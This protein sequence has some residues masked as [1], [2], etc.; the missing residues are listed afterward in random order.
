VASHKG[1]AFYQIWAMAV[2]TVSLRSFGILAIESRVLDLGSLSLLSRVRVMMREWI[3]VH[4]LRIADD[5]DTLSEQQQQEYKRGSPSVLFAFTARRLSRIFLLYAIDQT[6]LMLASF[7]S[8]ELGVM[9]WDL[10]PEKQAESYIAALDARHLVLRGY[11]SV[12]WIPQSYWMFTGAH[13]LFSVLFVS[14]FA[15]VSNLYR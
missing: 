3:D 7:I 10:A 6:E 13:D 8:E 15:L 2:L 4:G 14:V 1:F 12:R 5:E 11:E 9:V